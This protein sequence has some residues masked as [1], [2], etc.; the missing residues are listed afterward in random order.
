[1]SAGSRTHRKRECFD[2]AL[3]EHKA[4]APLDRQKLYAMAPRAVKGQDAPNAKRMRVRV[5]V[6]A[7]M[8]VHVR[9]CVCARQSVLTWHMDGAHP[10]GQADV[11]KRQPTAAAAQTAPS[12][13]Q[14]ALRCEACPL[15]CERAPQGLGRCRARPDASTTDES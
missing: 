11:A 10:T 14:S 15:I 6:R 12:R 9:A 5:Y 8:C 4:A 13:R 2:C 7:C 3:V 1:M